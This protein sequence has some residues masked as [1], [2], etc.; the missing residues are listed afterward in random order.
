MGSFFSFYG[1]LYDYKSDSDRFYKRHN[2]IIDDKT[3]YVEQTA[4]NEKYL[5]VLL[6]GENQQRK[7]INVYDDNFSIVASWDF[8]FMNISPIDMKENE[9]LIYLLTYNKDDDSYSMLKVDVFGQKYDV[10]S[11]DVKRNSSYDDN[12]TMIYVGSEFV[13]GVNC[14]GIKSYK[15]TEFFKKTIDDVSHIYLD[16]VDISLTQSTIEIAYN[17]SS[18][19]FEKCDSFNTFYSK[20]Y[21]LER[22]VL[23]ATYDH[24]END[25]CGAFGDYLCI[26]SLGRSYL[27]CFDLDTKELSLIDDFDKG[28]FLIEYD[29]NNVAYYFN[30]ALY[31]NELLN[32][33]CE[34][35]MPGSLEKIKG[36]KTFRIGEEKANYY[37]SFYNH[38]FY[39]L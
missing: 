9:D 34:N 37:L 3:Y 31:E 7:M 17:D 2:F 30:G 19:S 14:I 18:F 13:L 38:S 39:G 23:F 15:K 20:A 36:G 29:L 5:Y 28:T 6:F 35:I 12:G 8:S 27:F 32:R 26:C 10:I 16:S 11:N 1:E 4:L 24:L 22:C 33:P 21:L 25:E